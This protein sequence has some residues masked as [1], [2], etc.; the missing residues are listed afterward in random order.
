MCGKWCRSL[1]SYEITE[2]REKI[3]GYLAKRLTEREMGKL[4]GVA[5]TTVHRDIRALKEHS[6][7]FVNDIAKYFGYYYQEAIE[8][9]NQ[10]SKE[11]WQIYHNESNPKVKLAAL[12]LIKECSK[13]KF[14]LLAD[15]PAVLG[16]QKMG[17]R[18]EEASKTS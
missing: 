15:G 11:A 14:N 10:T 16:V 12:A 17:E 1:N 4:L 9:I 2:R 7:D 8:G 3:L 5:H 18:H 6:K 13:D